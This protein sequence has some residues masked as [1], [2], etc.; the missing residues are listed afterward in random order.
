VP[1]QIKIKVRH[2]LV[3]CAYCHDVVADGKTCFTCRTRIH[4]D[5][6]YLAGCCPTLGCE[7]LRG[8]G[9]QAG[10]VAT[11]A[12]APAEGGRSSCCLLW[13]FFQIGLCF[14]AFCTMGNRRQPPVQH[15]LDRESGYGVPAT[16][17]SR[18][19]HKA[20]LE[21]LRVDLEQQRLRTLEA[22]RDQ[23]H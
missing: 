4:T 18:T 19:E 9:E 12:S 5:C 23:E 22:R 1:P 13:A 21:K 17:Q 15:P 7:G 3:R 20:L 6:L 16:G 11:A 8:M 2:C 10:R 14:I